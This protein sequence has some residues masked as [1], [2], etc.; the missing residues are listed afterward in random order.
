MFF[1]AVICATLAVL[2]TGDAHPQL[3]DETQTP[4]LDDDPDCNGKRRASHVLDH[5]TVKCGGDTLLPLNNSE[6]CYLS[7]VQQMEPQLPPVE[8]AEA[9]KEEG[10][11]KDGICVKPQDSQ[12]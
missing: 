11:C 4:P 8:R 9:Q 10:V 12:P 6:R 7:G 5:C 1:A 2:I 3:P